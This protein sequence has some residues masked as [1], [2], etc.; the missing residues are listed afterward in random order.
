MQQRNTKKPPST[1]WAEPHR[2]LGRFAMHTSS[3]REVRDWLRRRMAL[4]P[5]GA[6]IPAQIAEDAIL[7]TSELATNALLHTPDS[8]GRG[9]FVVS[10]FFYTDCLRIS[11]RGPVADS[12]RRP[13]SVLRHTRQGRGS[14]AYGRGLF[15]VNALARTWGSVAAR[16]GTEVY[17]TLSWPQAD[18]ARA[19]HDV[20]VPR[21]VHPSSSTWTRPASRAAGW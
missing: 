10:A 7:M 13:D 19:A 11:V 17:F 1:H 14:V 9:A 8:G 4:R 5:T 2:H 21:A 20:R 15:L 18:R 16:Q 3:V 6:L 12:V